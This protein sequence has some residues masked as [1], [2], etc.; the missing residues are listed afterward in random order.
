MVLKQLRNN[1]RVKDD[2]LDAVHSVCNAAAR[3]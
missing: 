2:E 3:I 1:E